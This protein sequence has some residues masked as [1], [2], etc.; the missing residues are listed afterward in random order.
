M[1]TIT[2]CEHTQRKEFCTECNK[3]KSITSLDWSSKQKQF[4][5]DR[6]GDELEI[7]S[8]FDGLREVR[9]ITIKGFPKLA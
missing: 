9:T 5:Q 4:V 3:P 6:N 1:K 8:W 7:I 2:V